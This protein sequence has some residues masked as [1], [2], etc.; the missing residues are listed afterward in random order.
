[1]L[2]QG[3][4]SAYEKRVLSP[5]PQSEGGPEAVQGSLSDSYRCIAVFHSCGSLLNPVVRKTLLHF[6]RSD[7]YTPCEVQKP[8]PSETI[9]SESHETEDWITY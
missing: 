5:C 4:W 3:T 2:A 6:A 1:M 8:S 9:N 7:G